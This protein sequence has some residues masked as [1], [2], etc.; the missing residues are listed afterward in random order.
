MKKAIKSEVYS[1]LQNHTWELVNLPIVNLGGSKW[2][3]KR[4]MKPGGSIDKYNDILVIKGYK[5]WE[6]LDYFYTYSPMSRINF[7]PMILVIGALRNLEVH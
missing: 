6:G 2:I 5:Q 3:F 4:K 7:I 1:I